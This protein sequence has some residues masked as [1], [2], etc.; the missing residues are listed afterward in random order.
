MSKSLSHYLIVEGEDLAIHDAS[1]E[2]EAFKDFKDSPPIEGTCLL[3]AVY[4]DSWDS[5]PWSHLL[6]ASYTDGELSVHEKEFFHSMGAPA[7]TPS[8]NI[9]D[10]VRLT[11]DCKKRLVRKSK[12]AFLD[13]EI[14]ASEYDLLKKYLDGD[15]IWK[16]SKILGKETSTDRQFELLPSIGKH[17]LEFE[18]IADD[19]ILVKAAKIPKKK[20]KK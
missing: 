8:Y 11:P 1:K 6:L 9:G 2:E 13:G 5:E 10:A 15:S 14:F 20:G 18:I 12:T 4:F 17:N 19:L 3:F 16:I 7:A